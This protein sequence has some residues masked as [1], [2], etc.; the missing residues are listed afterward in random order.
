MK[1][2]SIILAAV[3]CLMAGPASAEEATEDYRDFKVYCSVAF[4]AKTF[5]IKPE[6]KDKDLSKAQCRREIRSKEATIKKTP[7]MNISTPFVGCWLY[8]EQLYGPSLK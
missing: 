5:T 3:A 6:W 2:L 8:C 1:H 7:R 4:D